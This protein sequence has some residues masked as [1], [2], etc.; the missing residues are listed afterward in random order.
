MSLLEKTFKTFALLSL[1]LILTGGWI[2]RWPGGMLDLA[3]MEVPGIVLTLLAV[4]LYRFQPESFERIATIFDRTLARLS[5]K[6]FHFLVGVVVLLFVAR[7]L[8]HY[9]LF[10]DLWDVLPVHQSLFYAFGPKILHCEVCRVGTV[11]GEH[12]MFTFLLLGPLTAFLHFDVWIFFIKSVV[13]LSGLIYLV[14]RGPLPNQQKVIFFGLLLVFCSGALK[15]SF[16]WDFC[17]DDLGFLFLMLCAVNV[18]NNQIGWAIFNGLLASFSKE[19]FPI[20]VAALSVPMF[21]DRRQRIPS[22][23]WGVAFLGLLIVNL[24]WI[25]PA[26]NGVSESQHNILL[27][28]PGLGSTFQE[29]VWNLVTTPTLWWT[30]FLSK[31]FTASAIHYV[32]LLLCPFAW[33]FTS[34]KAL[35]WAFP[36]LPSIFLNAISG[37][38]N[39]RMMIFHYELI[40]LPFL[41]L[42][43]FE[44]LRVKWPTPKQGLLVLCV[45]LIGFS[46]S[47]VFELTRYLPY[48]D[49]IPSTLALGSQKYN[50]PVLGDSKSLSHLS[51]LQQVRWLK[52]PEPE[53]VPPSDISA[54]WQQFLALNPVLK[55]GDQGIDIQDAKVL[56][57]NRLNNFEVQMESLL[58]PLS[59]TK[60]DLGLFTV[61]EF[62]QSVLETICSSSKVCRN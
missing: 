51:H 20:C 39:Q 19:N 1:F 8:R 58:S 60:K 15:A 41:A 2:I 16:M 5:G 34:R 62:D 49:R 22:V 9:T 35:L 14:K 23:L 11:L 44:A 18:Y 27:R 50:E 42:G 13:L 25:I 29:A 33:I 12:S 30:V 45:A 31:I 40:I 38:P 37:T 24:V 48:A 55:I 17:E 59:K 43:L 21:F 46:Y 32:V 10:T 57:L 61:L 26:I 7:T 36:A 56:V 52:V 28:L 54:F 53:V 4:L 3:K 47:P 6:W